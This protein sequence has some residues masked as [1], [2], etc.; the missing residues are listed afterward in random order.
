MSTAELFN[1]Q[2]DAGAGEIVATEGQTT[3]P[4]TPQGTGQE[5]GQE[6]S[7]VTYEAD[8][9]KE[10]AG[11]KYQ[12]VEAAF[13]GYNDFGDLVKKKSSMI[14][15]LEAKTADLEGRWKTA[16]GILGAPVNDK[17]EPA[18][19]DLKLPEGGEF[20]PTLKGAFEEFCR[21]HNL[22]NAVA[23]KALDDVVIPWE[24]G[25]EA[26]RREVE[27]SIVVNALGGGDEAVAAKAVAE[28]F[29]WAS[30]LLG[31]DKEKIDR[32]QNGLGKYG[33][34]ILAL[35]DL[36]EAL[37]GVTIG[38]S[39]GGAAGLDSDGYQAIISSPGWQYDQAKM[40]RVVEYL[41]RSNP[42]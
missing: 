18:P 33:D 12:T 36:R 22:S 37:T 39:S 30:G 16:E 21:A 8:W 20:D 26:G 13:K 3:A 6:T 9:L 2:A 10:F 25:T 31:G 15:E 42:D 28:T 40:A 35:A 19:Y 7:S 5:S 41:N 4:E 11:G 27:K 34:A 38:K 23:Q 17:G 29:D 1:E 14:E 24:A 32:L